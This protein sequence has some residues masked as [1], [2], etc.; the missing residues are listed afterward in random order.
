MKAIPRLFFCVLVL[1]SLGLSG[2]SSAGSAETPLLVSASSPGSS[3]SPSIFIQKDDFDF[4]EVL[5]T[6]PISY[7]FIVKNDSRADL[8]IRD[9]SPS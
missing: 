6:Q 4:G 9:V 7:D 8:H 1:Y 2:Q 5:E 3:A